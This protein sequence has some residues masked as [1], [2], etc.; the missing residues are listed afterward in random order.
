MFRE[1]FAR[2]LGWSHR[3]TFCLGFRLCVDQHFTCDTVLVPTSV[4]FRLALAQTCCATRLTLCRDPIESS[5]CGAGETRRRTAGAES[6]E[7][8]SETRGNGFEFYRPLTASTEARVDSLSGWLSI[9]LP[10]CVCFLLLF[11]P[12]AHSH[13]GRNVFSQL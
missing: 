6:F 10:G 13:V 5:V 2:R 1:C 9:R 3:L 11:R 12:R 4:A 8:R 7:V